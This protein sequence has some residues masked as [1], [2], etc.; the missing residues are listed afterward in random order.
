MKMDQ[1]AVAVTNAQQR[2][3]V[4]EHFNLKERPWINDIVTCRSWV[5]GEGHK[6]HQNVAHLMFNY[7]MHMEFE[8]IQ[9]LEGPNWHLRSPWY[10][11][12]NPFFSHVGV[13]LDEWEAWPTE[14]NT[15]RL[16]QKTITLEHTNTDFS[17]PRSELFGRQYQYQIYAFSPGC[18]FKYIKRIQ[19]PTERTTP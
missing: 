16:V 12:G 6:E 2:D 1:I 4:M 3:V 7:S 17:N 10:G 5:L 19:P 8:I 9:W 14:T 11:L 18:Y 15:C 13:H